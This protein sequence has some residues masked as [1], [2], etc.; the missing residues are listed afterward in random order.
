MTASV[1][2]V[3]YLGALFWYAAS[4]KSGSIDGL[5]AVGAPIVLRL[6]GTA[7]LGLGLGMMAF[8]RPPGEAILLWLSTGMAAFS[9]LVIVVPL[10][11][12]FVVVTGL[13]ALVLA[14]LGLWL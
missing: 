3:T 8:A 9:L 4:P 6:V 14:V 11:N 10:L 7:L 1:L 13:G 5:P 2:G 12:R